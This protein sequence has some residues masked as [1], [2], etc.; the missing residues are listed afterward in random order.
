VKRE[1]SRLIPG[2]IVALAG[3]SSSRRGRNVHAPRSVNDLGHE[4][5][6][7]QQSSAAATRHIEVDAARLACDRDP[8]GGE[9]IASIPPRRLAT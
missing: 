8:E 6:A 2:A 3:P 5:A 7:I 4:P 9:E 1:P